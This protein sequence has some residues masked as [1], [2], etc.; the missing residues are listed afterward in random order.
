MRQAV[1]KKDESAVATVEEK[2]HL[3]NHLPFD[4]TKKKG[5]TVDLYF[6]E[7]NSKK[8]ISQR[9]LRFIGTLFLS[10]IFLLTFPLVACLIK[11]FSE[12]TV[13]QKTAVPGKRGIVFQQ[14]TYPAEKM[15]QNSSAVARFLEKTGIYKLPSV[16]N[17]WKGQMN[18]I[19]P[20]AYAAEHCNKWNRRLSD[21]YKRFALPPGYIAVAPHI[22][23]TND[24]KEV[25]RSLEQ[26]LNYILSPTLKKDLSHLL[27]KG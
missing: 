13:L 27:N 9:I 18:L 25:A 3:E 5:P 23:D 19:G 10:L 14:Y 17:I 8:N 12:E 4:P 2:V 16:I 6:H 7:L 20:R 21:Y 24:L 11:L 1:T 22:A 26:E 15:S